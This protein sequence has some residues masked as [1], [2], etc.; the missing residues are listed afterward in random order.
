MP[1]HAFIDE[2][3]RDQ[4]YLLC[5]TLVAPAQLAPSRRELSSLLLPGAREL[6]FKKEKEPR[7]RRLI[8]RIAALEV[9]TSI[10]LAACTRKTEEETRQKCLERA[11]ADL[12]AKNAHRLVLDSRDHRDLHDRRTMQKAL[13][14]RPSK[15]ELTYEHLNST[16]E[17][18]LW[19]SDAVG[20]CFGAGGTWRRRASRLIDSVIEP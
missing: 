6:H 17:P 7:R 19:I 20:W 11:V 18:L 2:S 14:H 10:S 12:L 8:D 9:T 15:T 16:A 5:M 4:R 1:V 13:G 3:V